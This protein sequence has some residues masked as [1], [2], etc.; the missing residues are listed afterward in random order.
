[1]RVLIATVEYMPPDRLEWIAME[2]A[3]S[4]LDIVQECAAVNARWSLMLP[5]RKWVE[6]DSA[7]YQEHIKEMD[8]LEKAVEGLRRDTQLFVDAVLKIQDH[9][10]SDLV[11]LPWGDRPLSECTLHA[12]WHMSYH[13]GQLNYIQRLYGDDSDD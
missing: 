7:R 12:L 13:E 1:M 6:W 4:A 9:E 8:S 3:R 5:I 2:K 10:L 11:Q